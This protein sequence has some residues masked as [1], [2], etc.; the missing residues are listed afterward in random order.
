MTDERTQHGDI[1][2]WIGRPGQRIE[3]HAGGRGADYDLPRVNT[4][5]RMRRRAA[6]V[7]YLALWVP[8]LA[9]PWCLVIYV[10]LII[11]RAALAAGHWLRVEVEVDRWS[12][13][14]IAALVIVA[15]VMLPEAALSW[16][17]FRW[18][19]D[20]ASWHWLRMHPLWVLL[21][22]VAI[23][24]PLVAWREEAYL[25]DRQRRETVLPTS[26]SPAFET[27]PLHTIS[28]PGL[29]PL[30]HDPEAPAEPQAAQVVRPVPLRTRAHPVARVQ[31]PD[32]RTIEHSRLVE[33]LE[34][35]IDD[36]SRQ[37]AG[38][39]WRAWRR[40]WKRTDW[41]IALAVLV[42]MGI[43]TEPQSGQT[44]R[45]QMSAE[46]ALEAVWELV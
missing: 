1:D 5:D 24:A 14:A 25:T 29:W 46:D 22:A 44:T 9:G 42:E 31:A 33:M 13:V 19:I 3:E 27:A 38:F 34:A 41:E 37:P 39:S 36:N 21:R 4:W 17:P 26:S 10:P 40:Y 7:V 16:W 15:L 35:Q 32:G 18:Q 12:L 43:I 45:L 23:V 6:E 20:R 30:V 2:G 28:A 11:E 8:A